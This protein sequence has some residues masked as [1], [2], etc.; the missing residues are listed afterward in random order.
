MTA[1][2]RPTP[3][4]TP[5]PVALVGAGPGDPEL[6]TLDA[7][8]A[9]RSAREVVADRALAPLLASLAAERAGGVSD[10]GTAPV[11]TSPLRTATLVADDTPAPSALTAAAER[12][13]GVVRLYRGDPWAHPAGDAER[14]ALRAAGRSWSST[15]G[16]LG[17]LAALAAAGIPVQVR[18]LAVTTT[19]GHDALPADDGRQSAPD[20]GPATP[21]DPAHTVV[22][23][24]ADLATTAARLLRRAAADRRLD[25]RPVALVP[26]D[27]AAPLRTTLTRLADAGAGALA[28]DRAPS[29]GGL[30]VTGLVAALDLR[31]ADAGGPVDA[32]PALGAE[33]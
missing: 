3:G 16:V 31:A 18:D 10:A 17:E 21:A 8:A 32:A 19:F 13:P 14:A 29:G 20:P 6:L 27:G 5:A 2:R 12:G 26:A 23:R 33:R 28:G 24:T 15:P 22:V 11:A 1:D 25:D 9:L 4:L 7:E 30:I